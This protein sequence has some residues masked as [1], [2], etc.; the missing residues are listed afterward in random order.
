MR[1]LARSIARAKMRR[2]GVRQMSKKKYAAA[3]GR[4]ASY[5]S[6]HWREYAAR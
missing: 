4:P 6:L 5:F 1:K 3:G 2:D